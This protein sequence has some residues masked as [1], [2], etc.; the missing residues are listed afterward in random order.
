MTELR[1]DGG[2]LHGILTSRGVIEMKC[3]SPR[4]GASCDV[5][6][7]HRFHAESGA[8]L[9]TIQKKKIGDTP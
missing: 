1:C 3:N 9:Q 8:L 4:C 7:F 2:K 5:A 6:V